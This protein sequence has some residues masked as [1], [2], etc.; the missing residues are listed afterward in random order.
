MIQNESKKRKPEIKLFGSTQFQE[1]HPAVT[2]ATIELKTGK[3]I[4]KQPPDDSSEL[5]FFLL[6]KQQ[7]K[8][9]KFK[10]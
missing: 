8:K 6:T 9:N 1:T 10:V 5:I 7:L 2:I 4:N 3:S